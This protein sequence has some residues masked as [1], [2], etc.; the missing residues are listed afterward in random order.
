MTGEFARGEAATRAGLLLAPFGWLAATAWLRPLSLPDEGRYVGVA[1]EML[2]S[3]NWLVPT[4]ERL[5]YFHKPPLFYWLTAASMAVFGI[6]EWAGAAALCSAPRPARALAVSCSC[7]AGP[8]RRR[9]A[10]AL[11]VLATMPFFFGGRSSPTSTCWWPRASPRTILCAAHAVLAADDGR[12]RRARA[13]RRLC[14]S[15]RSACSP[16]G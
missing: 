14:S 3:G 11:L 7:A 15:P 5:P 4:L 6:N 16:K 12:P 10:L 9:R 8:A 1:L 2:W 13:G